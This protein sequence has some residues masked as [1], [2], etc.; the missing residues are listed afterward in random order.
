MLFLHDPPI[1]WCHTPPKTSYS[2]SVG[3]STSS[4]TCTSSA[5]FITQLCF[6]YRDVYICSEK[7]KSTTT[8]PSISTIYNYMSKCIPTLH[9]PHC[10]CGAA[11]MPLIPSSTTHITA[12]HITNPNRSR[13]VPCRYT[14]CTLCNMSFLLTFFYVSHTPRYY[15]PISQ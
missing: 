1:Y 14:T 2:G 4:I 13:L 11:N 12:T 5:F 6:P 9:P 15:L 8:Q 10:T 7:C 3:S